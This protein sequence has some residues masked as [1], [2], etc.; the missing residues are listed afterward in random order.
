KV[1]V[2]FF[3]M[4]RCPDAALMEQVFAEVVPQVHT[5]MDVK[6]NYFAKLDSNS[7][8]GAKCAH[9]EA[10]C[11]GNI[12]ELCALKHTKELP[13]FWRFL[14]CLNKKL[15]MV[16]DMDFTLECASAAG[17]D[18]AALLQCVGG[19]EGKELFRQSVENTVYS[20]VKRSATVFVAGQKRCVED[21]GWRECPGGHR[22]ED[23]VR[24]I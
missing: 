22:P 9:G 4:S 5:I 7:T 16:G 18:T 8:L 21:S 13:L 3:V 19:Q 23:F 6:L 2:E 12:H 15:D 17:L 14:V 10:E 11:H 1:P 24:D 20:G